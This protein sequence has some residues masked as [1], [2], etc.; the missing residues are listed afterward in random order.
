MRSSA[1]AWHEDLGSPSGR[2]HRQGPQGR[3]PVRIRITGVFD[4]P[5]LQ[6][7]YW[8]G[9]AAK[10]YFAFGREH[11]LRGPCFSPGRRSVRGQP[12]RLCA[13]LCYV[14]TLTIQSGLRPGV[15]GIGNASAVSAG[16]ARAGAARRGAGFEVETGLPALLSGPL[17]QRNLMGTVVV[18]AAV[19]LVLLAIWVLT[20]VL[21][22]SADLRRAELRVARLRGFPPP[23]PGRG[24]DHRA[25]SALRGRGRAGHRRCVGRRACR[26]VDPVRG[27]EPP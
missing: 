27:A 19:Q 15:L 10:P 18:V 22:R 9:D 2:D 3:S 25:G 12:R 6:S 11:R 16:H 7:A 13:P 14:R 1:I 8:F 21:M 26:C 17:H 4:L 23:T 20:S 24:V 5:N